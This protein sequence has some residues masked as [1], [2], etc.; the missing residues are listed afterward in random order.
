TTWT[1][2]SAAKIVFGRRAVEQVGE[3][4]RRLDARRVFL[5]TDRTLVAAGIVDEVF[6]P[7]H[8]AGIEIDVFSGGQAE[9]SLEVAEQ[10]IE[11]A[12]AFAP[13]AIVAVGGGSNMDV[14]KY[15]AA[16]LAHGGSPRDYFGEDRLPGPTLPVVCVPTTAGTGSEVSSSAVVSDP[17]A[18]TKVSMLSNWLRPA[19]AIVDPLLTVTCPPQVTADSGIDALVHAIEAF[20]AVDNES[21]PL[22]PGE[23]SV[24]QGINPL[25]DLTAREAIRLVGRHLVKAVKTGDDLD[26]RE[27][28]SL[29]ATL[30]GLA[31]SNTGVAI[32]HAMEYPVGVLTH[33]SHGAGNG[34][35][36]PFAMRFNLPARKERFAEIAEL[37]GES[38]AGLSIDAAAE[39]AIV[40]VEKLK[41]T[42][43]IPERLRDLGVQESHL[44]MLAEKAFGVKRLIRVNPRTVTQKDL[45]GVL[46]SAL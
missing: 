46:R 40:A 11:R 39:R 19:A 14:A 45:E 34:L 23:R 35:L 12:E 37:L 44:P 6:T 41:S 30:A 17:V 25:G 18:A 1:L 10:A 8:E 29:A 32:V 7:L 2:H 13:E 16:L 33:C 9:P 43:G 38:T 20:T 26:A 36:L 3:V 27:G 42:I 28:M 24:Y 21:F 5:V 31:F 15:V 22:P 4:V